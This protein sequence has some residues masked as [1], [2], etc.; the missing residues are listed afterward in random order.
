MLKGNIQDGNAFIYSCPTTIENP[1]C[2]KRIDNYLQLP[3]SSSVSLL[4]SE[5]LGD[6][7]EELKLSHPNDKYVA[8]RFGNFINPYDVLLSEVFRSGN[9]CVSKA[10]ANK[11]HYELASCA[12]MGSKT[13]EERDKV[14][15]QTTEYPLFAHYLAMNVHRYVLSETQSTTQSAQLAKLVQKSLRESYSPDLRLQGTIEK[16]YTSLLSMAFDNFLQPKHCCLHQCAI[17]GESIPDFYVA[18][19]QDGFPHT[20][21]N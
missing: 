8:S 20:V 4:S 15:S 14:F 21:Q 9:Y 6:L 13:K 16:T 12:S 3:Y 19:S 5:T 11:C 2:I 7:M 17:H 10:F 18:S 1:L